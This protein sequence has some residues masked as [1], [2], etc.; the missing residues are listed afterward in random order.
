M[1]MWHRRL[2]LIDHGASLY[3][4][5]T[6]GAIADLDRAAKPFP[7]IREHVLLRA[8][9]MIEQVDPLMTATLTDEVIAGIVNLIPTDWLVARA[10]DHAWDR[11]AYS[12]YLRDRLVPPRAFVAEAVRGR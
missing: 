1:L 11:P 2:W 4:H 5:H 7:L 8:A 3:F 6:P 10:T 9:S 12:R